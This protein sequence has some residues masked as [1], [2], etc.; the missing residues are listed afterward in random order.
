MSRHVILA[1]VRRPHL[2]HRLQP[3]V[4]PE[5]LAPLDP[6]VELLDQRFD[7]R[8]VHRQ[9][10]PPIS[11]MHLLAAARLSHPGKPKAAWELYEKIV[12]DSWGGKVEALIET[13]REQVERLRDT[14]SA[15][16]LKVVKLTLEYD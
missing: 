4:G 1:Q 8:T 15:E 7:Q 12:F 10:H 13:L 9:P 14:A 3:A 5:R 11:R 16:A 6:L 2:Q